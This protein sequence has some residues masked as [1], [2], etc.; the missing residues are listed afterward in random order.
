MRI[1]VKPNVKKTLESM[2]SSGYSFN[3]AL[4]DIID[5]S[6]DANANIIDIEIDIDKMQVLILDNGN[7]MS[8]EQMV[9]ALKLGSA[10][11]KKN[12]DLGKYGF[13]LKSASFSQCNVITVASKNGIT[14]NEITFDINKSIEEDEWIAERTSNYLEQI[15]YNA[16]T[17]VVWS[18]LYRLGN[19]YEEK[20]ERMIEIL[21]KLKIFLSK[22][23]YML[24]NDNDLMLRIN[25]IEVKPESPFYEESPATKIIHSDRFPFGNEEIYVKAYDIS[26]VKRRNTEN[27]YLE[28]QGFSVYRNDRFISNIGWMGRM[29]HPSLNMIRIKMNV[30]ANE[31]YLLN[32]DFKKSNVELP[33]AIKNELR[34]FEE[35]TIRIKAKQGRKVASRKK[36]AIGNAVE[37]LQQSKNKVNG[38]N[39][40]IDDLLSS[41]GV[42]AK[43]INEYYAT[44]RK[45]SKLAEQTKLSLLDEQYIYEYI[46]GMVTSKKATYEEL[47]LTEPFDRFGEIIENV[48]R[49]NETK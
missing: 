36:K 23:F 9:E 17:L 30:G 45:L 10:S 1:D 3:S 16:G 13:G 29:R 42:N 38:R 8:F 26:A 24:I 19:T 47:H 33:T 28:E 20:K 12:N 4:A 5:N 41:M 15:E 40:I 2:K 22:T 48:R 18:D 7:G 44:L 25:G 37:P 49:Q 21:S 14:S 32:I 11:S 34:K 46:E 6:I 43:E 27:N 35:A 31:D 39:V